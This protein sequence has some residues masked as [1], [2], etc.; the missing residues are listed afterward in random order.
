[1]W[2]GARAGIHIPVSGVRANRKE[3]PQ[4]EGGNWLRSF[5]EKYFNASPIVRASLLLRS[6]SHILLTARPAERSL[7]FI[8]KTQQY[9]NFDYP[10][11][12]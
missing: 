5:R 7:G 3:L 1:M 11:H 10:V 4:F 8:T 12:I 2:S 6:L 9:L